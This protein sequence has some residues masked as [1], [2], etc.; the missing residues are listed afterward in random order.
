[1]SIKEILAKVAKGE[2]LT[3]EE[4]TA[5]A[6]YD[7]DKALNDAAAAARRKAEQDA[8]EAKTKLKEL[9]DAAEAAKKATEDANKATQTEAQ[10]REAEFKA[11]Q[12]QVTALTE[13]KKAAEAKNAAT[14]RSQ[15]IREK[16][17][18]AGIALAPKT[19]SEKLFNQML[20]AHLSGIEAT[21]DDKLT[22]ALE[23]FK[24][25]NPGIIAAP[26][27]GSG[28]NSGTPESKI[29]QAEAQTAEQ[30][31]SDLKKSGII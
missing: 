9:Q 18:A 31:A 5:L 8:V 2:A 28:M 1:M 29:R 21:D 20:E 11:L 7:P 15:A 27:S 4:K 19:V 13:A 14:E 10:K 16:A 26:G 3:D 25:E 23:S 17:K 12:A 22:A 30:R 6:A 24:G